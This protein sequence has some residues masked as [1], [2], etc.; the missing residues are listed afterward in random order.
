MSATMRRI[1]ELERTQEWH[2]AFA[3]IERVIAWAV[4]T[5]QCTAAEGAMHLAQMKQAVPLAQFVAGKWTPPPVGNEEATDTM[6]AAF[7]AW[8]CKQGRDHLTPQ[9]QI[10]YV[11]WEQAPGGVS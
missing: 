10:L 4:A 8:E 5:N 11:A 3:G 6:M 9:Q 1:E 7:C 2:E